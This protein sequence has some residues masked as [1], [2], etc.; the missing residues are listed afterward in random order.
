MV[1]ARRADSLSFMLAK[2]LTRSLPAL[3]LALGLSGCGLGALTELGEPSEDNHGQFVFTIEPPRAKSMLKVSREV[4]AT[5]DIRRAVERLNERVQLPTDVAVVVRTCDEGSS[6][7]PSKR[8]IQVCLEDVVQVRELLQDDS[9]G[10]R[11]LVERGI[12][13]D[14]VNHEAAHALLH[15]YA[16]AFTGRE[17]DVADQ[18]SSYMSVRR[19]PTG[20]DDLESAAYGYELSA[21]AFEHESSDEHASDAQRA[22]NYQCYVYGTKKRDSAH[23]LSRKGLTKAR[24]EYCWEEWQDLRD[25]WHR[26]LGQAGALR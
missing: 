9:P 8:E 17:E 11:A 22:I 4:E 18:F 26:L 24:A 15:V 20:L 1:T 23:L 2:R 10:E 12:L 19:G 25:G 6:Y 21:A 3:A 7:E 5:G 13:V 14:L 16:I